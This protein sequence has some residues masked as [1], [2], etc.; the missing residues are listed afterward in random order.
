MKSFLLLAALFCLIPRQANGDQFHYNNVIIGDRA[1]GMGGAFA[2]IAD[3][4]SGVVYNPAGLAFALSN[5]ISG[6]A[7]AF[8]KKNVVYKNTLG[9]KNFTETSGGSLA[10]F[11]GGLQKL[12]DIHKGLVF[13][14][15]IRTIDSDLKD[16]NDLIKLTDFT[17]KATAAGD[18][19]PAHVARLHRTVTA[20]ESTSSF[21]FAVAKLLAPSIAMGF[22]VNLIMIEELV[23][24]FQDNQVK[25]SA[26]AE[27]NTQ[28]TQNIRNLLEAMY[29]EPSL[30]FQFAFASSFSFGLTL[31]FPMSLSQNYSSAVDSTRYNFKW[32]CKWTENGTIQADTTNAGTCA[33]LLAKNT[34]SKNGTNYTDIQIAQSVMDP[35]VQSETVDENPL[36]KPP[37]EVR[38]GLAWF[39]TARLALSTDITHYTEAKSGNMDYYKREAVTNFAAGSEFYFTPSLALRFGLFT[40]NDSRPVLDKS[41]NA[42]RDHVDYTGLSLFMAWVQPNSQVALGTVAQ[43]GSGEAQKT[44]SYDIQAVSASATT[45]AFSAT[46]SF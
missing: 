25:A 35:R 33:E 46:H 15:G 4:A 11:F 24:E 22:G 21:N 19:S 6:S 2:G 39:A 31:K 26:G 44:G 41:K 18:P 30:G 45:I 38:M 36:G 12:D 27:V 13:A 29:L 43:V 28:I 9:D 20:R 17:T 40:N 1:M 16:Q 42:Q 10:P 8:Y 37:S 23:Q 5:D 34:I 3:D 32:G 14:F 7:N